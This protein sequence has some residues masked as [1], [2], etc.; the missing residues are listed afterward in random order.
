MLLTKEGD[1]K[2]TTFYICMNETGAWI[3]QWSGEVR[4]INRRNPRLTESKPLQGQ[5]ISVQRS[6]GEENALLPDSLDVSADNYRL[7]FRDAVGKVI[8]SL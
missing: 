1:H 5:A 2:A 7:E 3:V 6:S 4:H 8:Y